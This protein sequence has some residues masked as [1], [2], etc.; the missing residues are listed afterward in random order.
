MF[1]RGAE[2]FKVVPKDDK[3]IYWAVSQAAPYRRMH[4]MGD[5]NFDK[6]SWASGGLLVNSIVEGRAGLTSG[7]QWMTRNSKIGSWQ[8][9]NWNRVFV[10]VEVL[11]AIHGLK[12]QPP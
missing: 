1:W 10:G 3:M 9:G 4:V 11:P 2:N 8:G 7:Q 5:I 12:N 6:G